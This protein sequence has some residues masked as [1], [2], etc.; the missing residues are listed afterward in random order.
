MP[1]GRGSS[2]STGDV[3]RR[4]DRRDRPVGEVRAGCSTG[5]AGSKQR[6]HAD[7]EAPW[8]G[9]LR[10]SSGGHGADIPVDPRPDRGEQRGRHREVARRARTHHNTPGRANPPPFHAPDRPCTIRTSSGPQPTGLT[11]RRR[12]APRRGAPVGRT[13]H[14]FATFQDR[15]KRGRGNRRSGCAPSCR[16]SSRLC[17]AGTRV[18]L[19]LRRCCEVAVAAA[20][21]ATHLAS[22]LQE[23]PERAAGHAR[24]LFQGYIDRWRG[25]VL[26]QPHGQDD[27]VLDHPAGLDTRRPANTVVRRARARASAAVR[28]RNHGAA[29]R[30]CRPIQCRCTRGRDRRHLRTEPRGV[31]CTGG[32]T[33]SAS[34]PQR[35]DLP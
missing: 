34:F 13:T 10:P 22:A 9:A 12:W 33:G 1:T 28:R 11:N 18:P 23:R 7:S 6:Q 24:A 5:L 31:R 27:R 25:P 16:R 14:D 29:R 2:R 32:G 35:G 17:M 19:V 3:H 4:R 26:N 30:D 15:P 8:L 21:L 20:R